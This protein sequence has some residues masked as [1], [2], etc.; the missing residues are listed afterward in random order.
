MYFFRPE[1]KKLN[2]NIDSKVL[3]I[4]IHDNHTYKLDDSAKNKLDKMRARVLKNETQFDEVSTLEISNKFQLR[5]PILDD[6]ELHFIDKLDECVEIIKNVSVPTKIK[7]ITNTNLLNMLFE[8]QIQKYTPSV[9]FGGNKVISLGFHVGKV[10]ASIEN[11]DNTA[12]EDTIVELDSKETYEHF[13]KADDEFYASIL[14]KSLKSEYPDSVLDVE[15]KY[16]MGPTTGYLTKKHDE[17]ALYNAIDVVKAYTHCLRSIEY[18][19]V[20]G[21]FDIYVPY[22]D[23]DIE[24]MTLY[25]VEVDASNIEECLLFPALNSRSLGFQLKFA[26]SNN[27]KF[28][29]KYFRR[30]CKLERVDYSEPVKKVYNNKNLEMFHKKYIVNKTTGL[31][32]KKHNSATLCKIFNSFSEAQFYQV[33]Y[34]GKIYSLQQSPDDPFED[35]EDEEDFI[36]KFALGIPQKKQS[37]VTKYNNVQGSQIH[38]L[39]VATVDN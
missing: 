16:Q 31:A 17:E 18:V 5:K 39:V 8:M 35:I 23:H 24:D 12:P 4:L 29:I 1:N 27:V 22:D 13:Y 34:G 3:C 6:C 33:K 28:S 7:F 20:F 25:C 11:T 15:T 26:Q 36:F 10:S 32:E 2:T 14:Q 37:K 38:V 19:P 9:R 21:Y 30:P